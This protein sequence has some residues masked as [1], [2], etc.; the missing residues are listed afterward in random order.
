MTLKQ[1]ISFL[2]GLI[3]TGL[4]YALIAYVI[5][6]GTFSLAGQTLTEKENREA[7]F[8]YSAFV[9]TTATIYIIVRRVKTNRKF[10]A[11]G[12]SIPLLF[13]FYA[14]IMLGQV[15]V[16]NLNYRQA[17]DKTEWAQSESKP[18]RMAK[19]LIKNK[20]LIGQSKQQIIDNLG[21][22][23]DSLR[24]EKVDYLK[25]WTDNGTWQMRLYFKNDKVVDAYLY[26]EGLDL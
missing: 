23:K 13:A 15:Y 22:T 21:L 7:F 2:S 17:F 12:I 24:N 18:F 11:I 25:Y 5:V 4:V 8:F 10:S 1:F 26:E 20:A 19:T 3:F 6:F 16:N 9:I 14:C